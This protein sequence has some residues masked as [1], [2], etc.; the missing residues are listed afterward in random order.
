MDAVEY[1]TFACKYISTF[2][3]KS[4][5]FICYLACKHATFP[6]ERRYNDGIL[7]NVHVQS[8]VPGTLSRVL[9]L[10]EKFLASFAQFGRDIWTYGQT[11]ASK[12]DRSYFRSIKQ[13]KHSLRCFPLCLKMLLFVQK[14]CFPSVEMTVPC[15]V[16]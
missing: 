13:N 16:R 1:R 8:K 14:R 7:H 12:D 15:E 9:S 11:F 10:L 6:K 5:T 2:L 4:S 3:T